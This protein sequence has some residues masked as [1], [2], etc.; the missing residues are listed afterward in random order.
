MSEN[1]QSAY[2]EE[3]AVHKRTAKEIS[4]QLDRLESVPR[5][6]GDDF[7]EQV[8]ESAREARRGVLKRAK[9]EPYF[10]R[11]DF[12]EEGK[13]EAMALYIGKNGIEDEQSR[14]L[15]VIDW[16]AP[17][18]GLFYS[19]TGGEDSASYESPD[20]TIDG[21]VHLKRN[22]VIRKQELQ[23][24]VDSYVRG[25]EGNATGVSDEFLLYRLGENKDNRLRDIVSTIQAEQDKIIRGERNTAL[26]IQGVAGSGKT[27]VALHRLAFLLYQYRESVRAERMIIFAPN[28]MFLDY[29]SGVLPELGVGEIRQTTFADWALNRLQEELKLADPADEY[30]KW[31]AV[32]AKRPSIEA[33]KNS[34]YKG[35]I[36]YQSLLDE[37]MKRFE[38]SFIPPQDYHPWD[39]ATLRAKE[40]R[41][42]FYEEYGHYPLAK[43]KE[44]LEGRIKTLVG[45]GVGQNPQRVGP[46]GIQ[47]ERVRTSAYLSEAAA[48]YVALRLV[49]ASIRRCKVTGL[50]SG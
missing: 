23:R 45:D 21:T 27:T 32:G 31:F 39:G 15:M 30:G 44:R 43:R 36:A 1:D 25:G 9:D 46:Q 12:Q 38:E 16:R 5:Y 48:R 20:G 10:G 2:L 18:A 47:K 35:S 29:I 3:A 22:I 13:P 41:K 7:T 37:A 6:F 24:V 11:L 40:I 26:F 34:R 28:R 14:K 4:R 50:A 42:W 8:L 33:E 49:H 17:V 19:F